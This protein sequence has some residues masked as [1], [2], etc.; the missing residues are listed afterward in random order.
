VED[1]IAIKVK[2][3]VGLEHNFSISKTE[4]QHTIAILN[5]EKKA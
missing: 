1:I 2:D 3:A 5:I 4:T